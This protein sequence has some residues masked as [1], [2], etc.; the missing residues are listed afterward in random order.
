VNVT[1]PNDVSKAME[2]ATAIFRSPLRGLVTS[3]GISGEVDAVD[4]SP[5]DFRKILDINVMGTFICAQAAA[6]EMHKHNSEGSIVL[7]ASMS[8]SV[9]NKVGLRSP[10]HTKYLTS[11]KGVNISAYNSSKSAVIQFARSLAAEWGASSGKAPIRVNSLS[12]GYIATPLSASARNRP[13]I[14]KQWV[15]DNML[16]RISLAEEYRAPV[17]FLLR[18]GSSFLTGHDLK[19]DGGHTAW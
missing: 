16:H 3:A 18:D 13:D 6:R 1:D 17:L 11:Y 10:I 12:P 19:C 2:E 9:A 8:G 7:I 14:L 5:D 4:Y 15:G